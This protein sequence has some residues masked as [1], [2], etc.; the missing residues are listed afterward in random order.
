MISLL[1][2]LKN[3]FPNTSRTIVN[4]SIGKDKTWM[5]VYSRFGRKPFADIHKVEGL[6]GMYIASQLKDNGTST[7]QQVSMI[8]FNKGGRWRYLTA[9]SRDSAGHDIR[10]SRF[11]LHVS[12]TDVF[13]A[14][15]QNRTLLVKIFI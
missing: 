14:A 2:K 7:F 5:F 12:I 9:P 3:T 10:C 4:D 6:R 13:D 11:A 1:T 8:T 15:C